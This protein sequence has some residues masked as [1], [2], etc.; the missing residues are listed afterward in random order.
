MLIALLYMSMV[1]VGPN[2][3]D[4]TKENLAPQILIEWNLT[5][6]IFFLLTVP[7]KWHEFRPVPFTMVY[8]KPKSL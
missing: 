4:G 2:N 6:S 1:R 8:S 5:A 7:L 3:F